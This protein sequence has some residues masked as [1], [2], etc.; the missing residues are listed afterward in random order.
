[1][2][3][4]ILEDTNLQTKRKFESTDVDHDGSIVKRS[5]ASGQQIQSFSNQTDSYSEHNLLHFSDDVMLYIL[6]YCSPRELKALSFCCRRLARLCMDRSL[7]RVVELR[8]QALG[9]NALNFYAHCLKSTTAN[10]YIRGLVGSGST[11]SNIPRNSKVLPPGPS[12]CD[13]VHPINPAR[14][15][16]DGYNDRSEN[17]RAK[18][19]S[20]KSNSKDLDEQGPSSKKGETSKCSSSFNETD[21][22]TKNVVNTDDTKNSTSDLKFEASNQPGTSAFSSHRSPKESG[23]TSPKPFSP[24]YEEYALHTAKLSDLKS[25]HKKKEPQNRAT[26]EPK[27]VADCCRHEN[28]C[29]A[30]ITK[31]I[32]LQIRQKCI[33]LRD[34]RLEYC[35]LNCNTFLLSEFPRTLKVLSLKGCKRTNVPFQKPYLFKIQDYLSGLEELDLSYCRWLSGH[36]LLLLSKMLRLKKLWLRGCIGLG[37]CVAYASLSTRFGFKSL[38]LLDVRGT[39]MGDSEVSSFSFLMNLRELYLEPPCSDIDVE[40]PI[41]WP[42]HSGVMETWE[43]DYPCNEV[44]EYIQMMN[45]DEIPCENSESEFIRGYIYRFN[46]DISS[47]QAEKVYGCNVTNANID[48]DNMNHPENIGVFY[49]SV[50]NVSF[51]ERNPLNGDDQNLDVEG[52]NN[53]PLPVPD[54]QQPAPEADVENGI[55]VQV[56]PLG[57]QVGPLG[58]QVGPVGVQVGH[59]GVQVGPVRLQMR[60]VPRVDRAQP[61]NGA[62]QGLRGMQVGPVEV[63]VGPDGVQVGLGGVGVEPVCVRAGPE[64]GVQVELGGVR[65][66]PGWMQI[67]PGVHVGFEGVEVGPV[68]VQVGPEGGQGPEE[69]RE[70]PEGLQVGPIEVQVGP[71][72]LEVGRGGRQMDRPDQRNEGRL[73]NPENI[74]N[75]LQRRPEEQQVNPGQVNEAG[76]AQDAYINGAQLRDRQP[77]DLPG[78]QIDPIWV[79]EN[80]DPERRLQIGF[81]VHLRAGQAHP[82][83]VQQNHDRLQGPDVPQVGANNRNLN[84][85]GGVPDNGNPQR[86]RED[87][88][89]PMEWMQMG[90]EE[91]QGNIREQVGHRGVVIFP[92]RVRVGNLNMRQD[93]VEGQ[94]RHGGLVNGVR[95]ANLDAQRANLDERIIDRNVQ[96]IERLVLQRALRRAFEIFDHAPPPEGGRQREQRRQNE[97]ARP[98]AQPRQNQQPNVRFQQNEVQANRPAGLNDGPEREGQARP[99]GQASLELRVREGRMGARGPARPDEQPQLD[100]LARPEGQGRPDGR[101]RP[102]ERQDGQHNIMDGRVHVIY[103]NPQYPRRPAAEVLVAA[104]MPR[105]AGLMMF[106]GGNLWRAREDFQLRDLQHV[107]DLQLPL[108]NPLA[109]LQHLGGADLV[110]DASLLHFG[111]SERLVHMGGLQVNR[112]RYS[113][114]EVLI[115]RGY[116]GVTDQTLAH[117]T[118]AAPALRHLD[119]VGCGVTSAG[120]TAFA[121]HRPDCKL[122]YNTNESSDQPADG[123]Q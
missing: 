21:E 9:V 88:R 118:A 36:S 27:V 55:G 98:E 43:S 69:R 52:M 80:V 33:N 51:E 20:T 86:D 78:A 113:P 87:N 121:M 64:G 117:L 100:E 11:K 97:Q 16:Y 34:L 47:D 90:G 102:D 22:S 45:K 61:E 112:R 58:V 119:V 38:E 10:L 41:D 50:V 13:C 74:P 6:N 31:D 71:V 42:E 91:G 96:N 23:N 24:S 7:W 25:E 40:T 5:K 101:G 120:A 8:Q 63:Q 79:N 30:S 46:S 4:F 62:Q 1:M 89:R 94:C 123:P 57:V 110:T 67:A 37:E 17:S 111:D 35:N 95:E 103:V 28:V 72:R 77:A 122:H 73:A 114:L 49:R 76:D 84:I 3:D 68:E 29:I 109:H 32:M 18:T 44:D 60:E 92:E 65:V 48:D 104:G 39:S 59:A 115:C 81:N 54:R 2:E 105:N 82:R 12:N 85:N 53:D 99:N 70:P 26:F 19:A 106:E 107:L 14:R 75:I 108:W 83:R 93:P 66:D 116:R 15:F 56:G